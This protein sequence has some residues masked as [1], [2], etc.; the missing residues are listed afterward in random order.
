MI[1]LSHVDYIACRR[2]V[3]A[4]HPIPRVSVNSIPYILQDNITESS[5]EFR[6]A[7]TYPRGFT[8][9]DTGATLRTWGVRDGDSCNQHIGYVPIRPGL[10]L[11][12]PNIYQHRETAFRLLDDS[13]SGHLKAVWFYL[14]DPEIEPVISTSRVGPQQKSWVHKALDDFLD[15]RLPHEVIERILGYVEGIMPVEEA[16]MYRKRSLEENHQFTQ[17][18]NSYHFCIPFDIWNGPE[19]IH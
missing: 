12:F 11:V 17:A 18:N 7:V 5:I 6:M 3:F 13:R 10:A 19:I 4:R 9:G 8:A 2:W 15:K 16:M 1:A 14:V